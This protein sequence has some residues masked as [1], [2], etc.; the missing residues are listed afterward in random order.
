M[1]ACQIPSKC[2]SSIKASYVQNLVN[3]DFSDM[4]KKTVVEISVWHHQCH[5]I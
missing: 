4:K 5:I 2:E 1:N 3:A